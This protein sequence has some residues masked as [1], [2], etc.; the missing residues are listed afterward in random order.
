M[1]RGGRRGDNGGERAGDGEIAARGGVN[2]EQRRRGPRPE[3][4]GGAQ[5][6]PGRCHPP[7]GPGTGRGAVLPG[8]WPVCAGRHGCQGTGLHHLQ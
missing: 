3:P 4:R 2:G 1:S 7:S 5:L 6:D 8:R